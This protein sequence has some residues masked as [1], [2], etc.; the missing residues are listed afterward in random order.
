ME[1]V[2]AEGLDLLRQ[3]SI[4]TFREAYGAMTTAEDMAKYL[5]SSFNRPRLREEMNNP[6]IRFFLIRDQKGSVAGYIKLRWDRPHPHFE[7][8]AVVELERL[9]VLK[10][11]WGQGLGA[12]AMEAIFDY[13]KQ[14]D[15]TWIW[16][17]V[18]WKNEAA[19]RF[20]RRFGFEK[21]GEMP[22]DF[23]GEITN[24]WVMKKRLE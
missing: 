4:Q 13:S 5:D 2:K 12:K 20:Y 7:E 3:L 15:Y 21:F 9:Y 6:A 11:Y 16:L 19:I 14:Q 10:A 18:W 17:L 1:L 24:D 22:F 8:Q 23:A